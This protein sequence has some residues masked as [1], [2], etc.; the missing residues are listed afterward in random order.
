L[1]DRNED[2]IIFAIGEAPGW[3]EIR[4]GRGF[5]GAAGRELFS[6]AAA[7]GLTRKEIKC[8]NLVKCLPHGAEKG[9]YKL[10]PEAIKSCSIHLEKELRAWSRI[11]MPVGEVAARTIAG[12]TPIRR[13]RGTV[14]KRQLLLKPSNGSS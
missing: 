1:T 3:D 9:D 11:V 12:L 8:G 2:A 7:V 10:D 4:E 5:V 6:L 13:W 14:L